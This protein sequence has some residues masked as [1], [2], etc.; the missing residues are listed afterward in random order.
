MNLYVSTEEVK[1]YLEI[2]GSARDA[3][4]DMLNKQAT[5]QINSILSVS[6]LALHKVTE[7]IHDGGSDKLELKDMK[8]RAIGTIIEDEDQTYTQDVDYDIDN[9]ILYL[10]DALQG[11][12]R[13]VLIDYVAGFHASG[14]ATLTVSAYASITG[15][16]T[17][18][19]DPAPTGSAFV[20]TEGTDWDAE[21]SNDVTAANIAAAINSEATGIRAFALANVVYI[22]DETPQRETT[23][24]VLSASTGL[25]LSGGTLSGVDFPEDIRQAVFLLISNGLARRKN[26]NM[27]SYTI[28]SKTVS[29]AS[30]SDADTFKALVKPYMRAKLFVI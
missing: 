21:T 1:T 15:G 10:D 8:V 19:I 28:G 25:T 23:T 26:P 29:F 20:M 13:D 27:Q 5:A 16:M 3:V 18:S 30:Q 9:Y 4:I 14:Y 12:K 6:D 17:I 22:I 7:E 11:G 2:T 24:V